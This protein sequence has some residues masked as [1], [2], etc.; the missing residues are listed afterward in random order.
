MYGLYH[1]IREDSKKRDEWLKSP[2]S[3]DDERRAHKIGMLYSLRHERWF[4]PDTT[5][6]EVLNQQNQ[7]YRRNSKFHSGRNYAYSVK[8]RATKKL[9]QWCNRNLKGNYSCDQE[10][11][12]F[13]DSSDAVIFKLTWGG[14]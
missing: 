2:P 12:T 7:Q 3:S 5:L 14:K 13:E 8:M 10:L 11:M 4:H 9:C 6:D 1:L